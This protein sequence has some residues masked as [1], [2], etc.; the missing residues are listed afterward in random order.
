MPDF[1]SGAVIPV[2]G[3]LDD[4]KGYADTR[5]RRSLI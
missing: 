3:M 5:L 2:E 1:C 4:P